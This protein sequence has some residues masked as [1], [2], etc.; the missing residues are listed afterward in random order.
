MEFLE[1][2]NDSNVLVNVPKERS[3]LSQITCCWD[4]YIKMVHYV[5]AFIY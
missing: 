1:D 4:F 3:V 2:K 5:S